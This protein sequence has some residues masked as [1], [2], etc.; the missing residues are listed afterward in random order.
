MGFVLL[1]MPQQ[2]KTYWITPDI[3]QKSVY[4]WLLPGFSETA[5]PSMN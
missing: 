5:A 4:S 1:A 2:I 3:R